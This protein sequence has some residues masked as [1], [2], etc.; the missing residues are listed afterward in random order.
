[1]I[2][3][4]EKWLLIETFKVAFELA[5]HQNV[6]IC[7]INFNSH[8]FVYYYVFIFYNIYL[9]LFSHTKIKICTYYTMY[10]LQYTCYR[11]RVC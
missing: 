11:I 9:I 3:K 8:N 2:F 6:I 4:I 1:M 7:S 5:V 10:I